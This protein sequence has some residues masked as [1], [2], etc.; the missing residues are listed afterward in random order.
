MIFESHAHYND[1]KFDTDRDEVIQSL[2]DKGVGTVINVGDTLRSSEDCIKLAEKYDFFY[3]AVGVHPESIREMAGEIPE[4]GEADLRGHLEKTGY[5]ETL[6]QQASADKV[7]SI[8]EI[9]L[10]YYWEKD[11]AYR[12]LQKAAFAGQ[13]DLAAELSL[14]VIIHSRDACKDTLDIIA[15]SPFADGRLKGV[16]HCYSYSPE[17]AEDLV[18]KYGFYIGV[19][20]VV[21]FKN[22]KNLKET[23]EKISMENILVETDCPYMAPEPHRGKRNYSGYLPYVVDKIAEIKGISSEEVERITEENGRRL[24]GIK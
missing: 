11:E 24:F 8:G 21:T 13:L 7:V 17:V 9:G 4:G 5:I 2:R 20:G 18:K 6:R 15:T 12:E 22:S 23:V 16:M 19:G 10:D 14:P 1:S 3:A